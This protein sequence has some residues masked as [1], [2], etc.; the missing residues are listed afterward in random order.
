[1]QVKM[2]SKERRGGEAR[3]GEM[4]REGEL[5]Y[6][7]RAGRHRERYRM[8]IAVIQPCS[9]HHTGACTALGYLHRSVKN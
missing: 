7:S 3:R 8:S 5:E 4:K 6:V 2:K 9:L 1:M